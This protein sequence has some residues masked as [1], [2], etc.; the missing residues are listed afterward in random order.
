MN[1]SVILHG[2]MEKQERERIKNRSLFLTK[3]VFSL[4]PRIIVCHNLVYCE[5]SCEMFEKTYIILSK[6]VIN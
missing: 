2:I 4:F 6:S 1:K 5:N 3:P